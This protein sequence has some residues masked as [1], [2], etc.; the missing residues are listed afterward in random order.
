[1]AFL[2][3]AADIDQWHAQEWQLT[4]R[5]GSG[6]GVIEF[7]L[8]LNHVSF[9]SLLLHYLFV[10]YV[11]VQ[12]CGHMYTQVHIHVATLVRVSECM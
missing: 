7:C 6:V 3:H 11:R 9:L 4:L 2:G 12:M 8:P 1:M 5:R 10:V